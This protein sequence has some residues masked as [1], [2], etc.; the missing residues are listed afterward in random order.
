MHSHARPLLG[1]ST[2]LRRDRVG[3]SSRRI[4]C[5]FR[6]SSSLI[7]AEGSQRPLYVHRP[8]A[9]PCMT[10]R[11][12]TSSRCSRRSP[13]SHLRCAL[14][15]NGNTTKCPRLPRPYP[16]D[17][18]QIHCSPRPCPLGLSLCSPEPAMIDRYQMIYTLGNLPRVL[19]VSHRLA[20]RRQLPPAAAW[21]APV[22]S[23]N[24]TAFN[25]PPASNTTPFCPF[26]QPPIPNWSSQSPRCAVLA[27]PG[28][29]SE[30]VARA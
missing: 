4:A 7:S 21:Y 1:G 16:L 17:Q 11:Q 8:A 29:V 10:A 6:P 23:S 3:F 24:S 15:H 19:L 30:R 2:T 18:H 28:T 14:L 26:Q 22:T 12:G 20:S 13:N 9:V 27:A 25:L 5:P